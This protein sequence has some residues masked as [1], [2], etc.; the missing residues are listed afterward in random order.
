MNAAMYSQIGAVKNKL[1]AMCMPHNI[2]SFV[3]QQKN[4]SGLFLTGTVKVNGSQMS[5]PT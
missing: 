2:F 5:Q 1:S 3:P 4:Y